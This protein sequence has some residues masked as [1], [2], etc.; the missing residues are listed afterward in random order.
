MRIMFP[1]VAMDFPRRRCF[2]KSRFG[3]R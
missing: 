3:N 1:A 2:E